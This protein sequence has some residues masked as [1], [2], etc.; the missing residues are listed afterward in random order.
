[1]EK[2]IKTE[3]CHLA[4]SSIEVNSKSHRQK[5]QTK[6]FRGGG[7]LLSCSLVKTCVCCFFAPV[8][9]SF[10]FRQEVTFKLLRY[11]RAF[12][13]KEQK[14]KRN[15]V[16]NLCF[17]PRAPPRKSTLCKVYLC[18]KLLVLFTKFILI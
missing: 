5:D 16:F 6:C 17:L 13:S 7:W 15:K 14:H 12:V 18:L 10:H 4:R 3:K 8:F 2:A 1:M 9:V 11:E